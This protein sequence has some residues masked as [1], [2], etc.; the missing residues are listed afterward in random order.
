MNNETRKQ[1]LQIPP[2]RIRLVIDTDAKNEVD[3]QFAIAW[4]LKS[5]ER[6][7]VEAIYAAPFFHECHRNF[8]AS[9]EDIKQTGSVLGSA[10]NPEDGMR[11]SYDEI[12]KIYDLVN[13]DSNGRVFYGSDRYIGADGSPVRSDAAYDLVSRARASEE[14][15]YVAALGAVTNIASAILLAP[16][17]IERIVVIWLGGQ[18]FE[19]GHGVEFNMMQDVKASQIILD[20][21]V[22]LAV[23][24]CMNVASML[25]VAEAELRENLKGKNQVSDYLY[26][27]VAEQFKDI[28]TEKS[29]MKVDRGGYLKGREDYDEQYLSQFET[30]YISWSRIIWDISVIAFLKNPNWVLSKY[31]PAPVLN[32]DLSYKNVDGRHI[33]KVATFCWRNFIF[34]DLFYCLAEKSV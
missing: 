30:L 31:V 18:P 29:F 25:S 27:T 32:S 10:K 19:F 9:E 20:S 13:M 5:P 34:G 22:P 21:G 3:D 28:E 14:T 15:L 4:A 8:N 17:I 16:D 24:P 1:K 12:K 26:T 6:F 23:I 11:Q 33:L 7:N 2:G